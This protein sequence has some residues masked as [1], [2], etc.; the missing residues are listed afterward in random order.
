MV[1]VRR[2]KWAQ[3]RSPELSRGRS[4]R[5][6]ALSA[7]MTTRTLPELPKACHVRLL[8]LG[9]EVVLITPET[10]EGT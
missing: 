4:A 8:A 10:V 7:N 5:C 6:F 3:T 1:L 2:P 9:V